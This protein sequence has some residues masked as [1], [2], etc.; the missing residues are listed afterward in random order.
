LQAAAH[1]LASAVAASTADTALQRI[2]QRTPRIGIRF[3]GLMLALV[4]PFN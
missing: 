1:W 4:P 3:M 2:A